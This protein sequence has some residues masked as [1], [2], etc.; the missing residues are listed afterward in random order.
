MQLRNLDAMLMLP[1]FSNYNAIGS[2]VFVL[3]RN[4]EGQVV[5][6]FL[7]TAGCRRLLCG[8]GDV[9]G[10][11]VADL[12]DGRAG[13]AAYERHCAAWDAEV[14]AAYEIPLTIGQET[15][16]VMTHLTPQFDATGALSHFVGMSL[17]ITMQKRL[18][19]AHTMTQAMTSEIEDFVRFAAHDLRSPIAN[20]KMLTDHLRD[21]FV[22]MGDGKVEI[23]DMI[24]N[25][26]ERALD[27]VSDV[28]VQTAAVQEEARPVQFEFSTMCE[29]VLAMLD[30]A[31]QH[32]VTMSDA[33]V[34][35]DF[36]AVQII[37]RNLVDN[38]LKYAGLARVV[39]HLDVAA[40]DEDHICITVT[41]NGKGFDDPALAFLEN[42]GSASKGGFGLLA[43]RRLVRTRGGTIS[44]KNAQVGAEI[45]VELPGRLIASAP[46][47]DIAMTGTARFF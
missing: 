3:T 39:L 17:D 14:E 40:L 20:V 28:L 12:F 16:W 41:D 23:I 15:I 22:D 27:L 25:I 7:N 46:G 36:A 32:N 47:H 5:Y 19:Q 31:R 26:S 34:D 8:P 38:A 18:E 1:D 21:G 30:P 13:M 11:T 45:R 43:V 2:P 37:V 9:V 35:A 42:D 44:V 29:N 10:K 24:E 6:A 4:T 33:L